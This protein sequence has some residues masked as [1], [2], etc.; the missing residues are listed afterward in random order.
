MTSM[1]GGNLPKPGIDGCQLFYFNIQ[2]SMNKKDVKLI[3]LL[4]H[5]KYSKHNIPNQCVY[6]DN[7]HTQTWKTFNDHFL[8]AKQWQLPIQNP[9]ILPS[10]DFLVFCF[11][12]LH[13]CVFNLRNFAVFF[14]FYFLFFL[15]LFVSFYVRFCFFF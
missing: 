2:G 10:I 1:M 13:V 5:I 6:F 7:D 8:F 15:C 14:N 4:S 3:A 11:F 9:L 12:F